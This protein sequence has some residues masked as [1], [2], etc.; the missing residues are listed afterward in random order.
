[1][2]FVDVNGCSKNR[3]KSIQCCVINIKV[4]LTMGIIWLLEELVDKPL[5]W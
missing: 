3:L 2:K 5:Q 1:M 4:A